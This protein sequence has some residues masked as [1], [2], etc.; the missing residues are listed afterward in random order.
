MGQTEFVNAGFKETF[1]ERNE[2]KPPLLPYFSEPFLCLR[3][4]GYGCQNG[5]NLPLRA[6]RNCK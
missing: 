3:F 5:A 1:I 4:V 6:V 2:R